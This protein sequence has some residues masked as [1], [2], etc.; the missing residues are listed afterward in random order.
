MII[1]IEKIGIRFLTQFL[2]IGIMRLF[3]LDGRYSL[4]NLSV[5]FMCMLYALIITVFMECFDQWVIHYSHHYYHIIIAIMMI[6]GVIIYLGDSMFHSILF[7]YLLVIL[8]KETWQLST[9]QLALERYQ[10]EYQDK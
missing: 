8:V 3:V 2:I 4:F 9:M 6:C 1:L 5:M 7:G 10:R